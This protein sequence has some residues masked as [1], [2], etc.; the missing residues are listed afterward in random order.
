MGRV[1]R[2]TALVGLLVG[3]GICFIIE[4]EA[5]IDRLP[6]VW[7]SPPVP[8][9]A[10]RPAPAAATPASD[11]LAAVAGEL[12]L[13]QARAVD[14]Q[15]VQ[16]LESGAAAVFTVLPEPQAT[17][18]TL[19][20]R[21]EV[22]FGA[23][24][25]LDPRDGRVLMWVEVARENPNFVGLARKSLA[26]AASIFKIVSAVALLET[27]GFDPALPMCFHG[28]RHRVDEAELRDDPRR[29][30]RC[31]TLADAFAHS[32]NTAFAKWAD[33]HL[34]A[35]RLARAAEALGFERPIP[36]VWPV[37]ASRAQLQGLS[38]LERARAAAGFGHTTLSPL[39][40]ALIAA[41][42]AR[43]G[44][45]PQPIL[46]QDVRVPD[47]APPVVVPSPSVWLRSMSSEVAAEL[48]AMMEAAVKDGTASREF[49]PDK[50]PAH[51]MGVPI[52]GKTGSLSS[53]G[54]E[55]FH[56]SWFVGFA[57]SDNPRVALA[58]L[59]IN[60][61]AWRLKALPVARAAFAALLQE[62]GVER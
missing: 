58:V 6:T 59:M 9:P 14:G 47:G 55:R 17:V 18:E 24:V 29:D 61:P 39:H 30:T 62:E 23:V 8:A 56:F 54:S 42:I 11:G 34:D 40:G 60:R 27:P 15:L 38:P 2:W 51:L 26:P 22:P 41:A 13:E 50:R 7:R 10:A 48:T 4:W 32:S 44:L 5:P 21:H 1:L 28:G 16:T 12:N 46:V 20:Q 52:A 33:R 31:E 53:S 19:I 3:I 43:G 37:E 36:L 35:L 45:M 49:A 25:A 57:P